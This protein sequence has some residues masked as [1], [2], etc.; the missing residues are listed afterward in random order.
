MTSTDIKRIAAEVV[1][2]M[3][4]E[5]LIPTPDKLLTLAEAAEMMKLSRWTFYKNKSRLPYIKRGGKI[6]YRESDILA[7]ING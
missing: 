6:Y 7:Y 2:Q 1:K 3:K 4:K 5:N